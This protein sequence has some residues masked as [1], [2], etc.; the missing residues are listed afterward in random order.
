MKYIYIFLGY[1]C[2]QHGDMCFV[3]L[4]LPRKDQKASEINYGPCIGQYTSKNLS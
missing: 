4:K 3:C 1:S 2:Q